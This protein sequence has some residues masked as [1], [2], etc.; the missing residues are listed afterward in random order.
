MQDQIIL[1][2]S[3]KRIMQ[4]LLRSWVKNELRIYGDIS[5][6]MVLDFMAKLGVPTD[7]IEEILENYD[8]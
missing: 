5:Y 3:E 2:E 8:K 1:N 4:C 7:S 6:Q